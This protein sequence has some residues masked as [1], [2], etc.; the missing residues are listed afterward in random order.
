[1]ARDHQ[2]RQKERKNSQPSGPGSHFFFIPLSEICR[3]KHYEGHFTRTIEITKVVEKFIVA[4]IGPRDTIFYMFYNQ[5]LYTWT[6]LFPDHKRYRYVISHLWTVGDNIFR[7]LSS[8][9]NVVRVYSQAYLSRSITQ[10]S[11]NNCMEII[12]RLEIDPIL[13]SSISYTAKFHHF[14]SDILDILAKLDLTLNSITDSVKRWP[15]KYQMSTSESTR[16]RLDWKFITQTHVVSSFVDPSSPNFTSRVRKTYESSWE[17]RV[18]WI[19][20]NNC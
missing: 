12:Q 10:D 9:W 7:V 16:V 6:W 5:T 2:L 1:M 20:L 13:I 3:T 17:K 11:K 4:M 15:L 14:R 8:Y 19:T 18:Y